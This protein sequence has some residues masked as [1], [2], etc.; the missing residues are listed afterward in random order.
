MVKLKK[1]IRLSLIDKFRTLLYYFPAEELGTDI[2]NALNDPT[3]PRSHVSHLLFINLL[4]RYN[5]LN[6][7][8]I[9][10]IMLCGKFDYEFP[11]GNSYFNACQTR[12]INEVNDAIFELKHSEDKGGRG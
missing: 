7:T 8:D 3:K 9:E 5:F 2:Y 11:A 6:I 4:H 10:L 12:A 1:S